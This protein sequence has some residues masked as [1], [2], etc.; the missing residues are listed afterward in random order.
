MTTA[1]RS[2]AIAVGHP[3]GALIEPAHK[4][5]TTY[6]HWADDDRSYTP[7]GRIRY[8]VG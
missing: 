3:K 2:D 6:D 1:G 4:M 5:T 8:V 7:T